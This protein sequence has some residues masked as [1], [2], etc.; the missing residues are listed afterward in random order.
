MLDYLIHAIKIEYGKTSYYRSFFI[1]ENDIEPLCNCKNG[2][3]DHSDALYCK[4][5][6]KKGIEYVVN[7]V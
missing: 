2:H 7:F 1:S 5:A 6:V 4:E 3:Q